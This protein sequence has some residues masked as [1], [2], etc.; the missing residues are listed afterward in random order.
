MT[1]I[2]SIFT[3][4]QWIGLGVMVVA[5]ALI[6]PGLAQRFVLWLEDRRID[7]AHAGHLAGCN[8]CRIEEDDGMAELN[9]EWQRVLAALEGDA[10]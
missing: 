7:R 4:H 1:T 8:W 3:P 6:L 10:A 9:A 2:T 5:G